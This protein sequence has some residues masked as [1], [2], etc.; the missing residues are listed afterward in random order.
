MGT[1][2]KFRRKPKNAG[3]LRG[4]PKPTPFRRPSRWGYV[5]AILVTL[6]VAAGGLIA[7]TWLSGEN[8]AADPAAFSCTFPS[9]TDGDTF[10]CGSRRVRLQGIDAPEMPGHCRAGRDC[11]QG[12]P[13]ASSD[14]LRRLMRWSTVQCRQTDI[15][16]YGRTIARCS[17]G[18]I[19][20]SCEQIKGGYAVQ[21]YAPISC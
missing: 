14:N 4:K 16:G 7:T 13:Y 10:R 5:Q 20:L 3:Q 15:D 19:D 1:V 17:V 2:H 11:T 21:R 12:D 6:G 8:A 9:V 18:K